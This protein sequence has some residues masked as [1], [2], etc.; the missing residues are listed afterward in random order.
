MLGPTAIVFAAAM[1]FAPPPFAAA[2]PPMTHGLHSSAA[3]DGSDETLADDIDK[4]FD[5]YDVLGSRSAMTLAVN[6]RVVATDD[7]P[8]SATVNGWNWT[9][10]LLG[11]TGLVLTSLP[12]P[13][14]RRPVFSS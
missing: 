14:V 8:A 11:C 1:L 2:R 10:L 5:P 12:R 7:E 4:E 6:G 13:R 3:I 9:F